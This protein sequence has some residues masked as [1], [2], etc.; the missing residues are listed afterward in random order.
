MRLAHNM[1]TR[2]TVAKPR[3][4]PTVMPTTS[5]RLRFRNL[6]LAEFGIGAIH[7][8]MAGLHT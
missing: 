6:G 3:E 1:K 2:E 7:G 5:W 8:M 4:V